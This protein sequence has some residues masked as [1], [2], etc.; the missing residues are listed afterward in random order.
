MTAKSLAKK[1]LRQIGNVSFCVRGYDYNSGWDDDEAGYLDLNKAEALG[2]I[3]EAM[4]SDYKLKSLVD[5]EDL[6][7]GIRKKP[8][9]IE[10][11]LNDI[12]F[13]AAWPNGGPRAYIKNYVP[14]ELSELS[15]EICFLDKSDED[16]EENLAKVRAKLQAIC[17]GY[18][19]LIADIR[20]NYDYV[21]AEDE[22]ITIKLT[23][24]MARGILYNDCYNHNITKKELFE[25]IP[26][27][28]TSES[29]VKAIVNKK[30][31]R[32]Y[33][34]GATG[35]CEA[36]QNFTKSWCQFIYAI[37]TEKVAKDNLEDCLTF[38]NEANFEDDIECDFNSWFEDYKENL[39]E[40]EE[41]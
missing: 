4:E 21:F 3:K 35:E 37:Y 11:A 22:E 28:N 1:A 30:N 8:I 34:D 24:R 18:F 39:E 36:L 20:G 25:G 5:I 17:S 38:L 40:M 29:K 16:F 31:F 13:D 9:D 32:A 12:A 23:D 15:D 41:E 27:R 7:K 14:T 26:Y 6:F 19:T 2:Q 10:K 33:A